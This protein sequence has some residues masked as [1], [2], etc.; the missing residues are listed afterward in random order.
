MKY[1]LLLLILLSSCYDDRYSGEMRML[2][3]VF[4]L[5]NKQIILRDTFDNHEIL[6]TF[7]ENKVISYNE[8]Y[9]N[10]NK[11]EMWFFKQN[12]FYYF[13]KICIKN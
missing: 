12:D 11:Y 8:Y 7:P 6:I 13:I 5:E 9:Q 10:Y 1:I 4:F 3:P 2:K